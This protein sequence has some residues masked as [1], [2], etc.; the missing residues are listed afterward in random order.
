MKLEVGHFYTRWGEHLQLSARI[1]TCTCR[2][3]RRHLDKKKT[4]FRSW[5]KRECKKSDGIFWKSEMGNLEFPTGVNCGE[6]SRRKWMESNVEMIQKLRPMTWSN[7]P[8]NCLCDSTVLWKRPCPK[9]T[10]YWSGDEWNAYLSKTDFPSADNSPKNNWLI[11]VFFC[12]LTPQKKIQVCF[13][14]W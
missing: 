3:A 13:T 14:G 6:K 8:I 2:I 7:K 5:D 4:A 12:M 1:K 10:G 9:D 11:Q